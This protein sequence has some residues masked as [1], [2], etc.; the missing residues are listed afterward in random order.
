MLGIQRK[1]E[2]K[3]SFALL[4]QASK[5]PYTFLLQI[6]NDINR[7]LK[8]SMKKCVPGYIDFASLLIINC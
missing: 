7:G 8:I 5:Y 3:L 2:R 4:T 6:K 1:F